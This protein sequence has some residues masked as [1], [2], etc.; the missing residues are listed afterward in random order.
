[1]CYIQTRKFSFN[2]RHI[3]IGTVSV[4]HLTVSLGLGPNLRKL[5]GELLVP[6]VTLGPNP[7]P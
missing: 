7:G 6:R 3:S 4:L 5:P 2:L 1:M